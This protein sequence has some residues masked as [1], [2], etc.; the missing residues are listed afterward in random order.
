MIKTSS[1]LGW[2]SLAIFNHL[3]N[4]DNLCNFL[5]NEWKLIGLALGNLLQWESLEIFQKCLEIVEKLSKTKSLV[6]LVNNI[7]NCVSYK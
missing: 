2:K 1:D 4:F 6:C 5:G 7:I 3:R